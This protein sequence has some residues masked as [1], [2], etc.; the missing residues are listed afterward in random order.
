MGPGGWDSL[1][2]FTPNLSW[3]L[4]APRTASRWVP[5]GGPRAQ[6]LGSHSDLPILDGRLS[7][8]DDCSHFTV[9]GTEVKE[10]GPSSSGQ[11]R[12]RLHTQV[13]WPQT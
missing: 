8:P 3:S 10:E 4:H 13:V 2:F 1:G 9:E 12:A 7:G 5:S 11:G 6:H